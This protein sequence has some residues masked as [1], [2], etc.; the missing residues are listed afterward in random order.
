MSIASLEK[1]KDPKR[2]SGYV[3]LFCAAMFL[4]LNIPKLIVDGIEVF[5]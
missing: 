2:F 4:V 1:P 5:S 3:V